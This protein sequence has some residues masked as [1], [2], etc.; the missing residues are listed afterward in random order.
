MFDEGLVYACFRSKR[1]QKYGWTK[2]SDEFMFI[3]KKSLE[4]SLNTVRI[5]VKKKYVNM[6]QNGRGKINEMKKCG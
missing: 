6:W 4:N 2:K 5:L 3:C 1:I